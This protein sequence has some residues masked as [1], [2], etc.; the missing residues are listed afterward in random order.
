M[1]I[2]ALIFVTFTLIGVMGGIAYVKWLKRRYK[3]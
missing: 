3:K 1:I 2:S